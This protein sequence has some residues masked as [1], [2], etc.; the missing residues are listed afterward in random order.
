MSVECQAVRAIE[1][2]NCADT[3]GSICACAHR[4]LAARDRGGD[5]QQA[6]ERIL[7]LQQWLQTLPGA[8]IGQ[9]ALPLVHHFATGVYV[10]EL[11]L[12]AGTIAVGEI[13]RF[14]CVNIVIGDVDVLTGGADESARELRGLNVFTTPAGVKR[15]VRTRSAVTWITV[16]ANPCDEHDG[17][18]MAARLT[19]PDFESLEG[20]ASHPPKLEG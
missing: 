13:H 7:A 17:E 4:E 5:V 6:R 11:R 3:D 2:K 14:D 12:P 20:S 8:L 18:R 16:H 10:R 15:A 1:R 19:V 9:H